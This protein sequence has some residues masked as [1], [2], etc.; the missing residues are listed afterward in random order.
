M[1]S[2]AAMR[3]TIKSVCCLV[4]SLTCAYG[5]LDPGQLDPFFYGKTCPQALS[6]VNSTVVQAI[7]KE[8]RI[9]AS[10][11]RL[12]FHDCFVNG[13]D[14]SVLLDDTSTFTGEK[15]ANANN[16]SARGFGLIDKIKKNL[17]EA[18][19]GVVSCA[20]ILAIAARDSVVM[21]GGPTWTVMLGRRDSR[22]ASL[23]VANS[24]IP[25]PASDLANLTSKFRDQGL[26][27]REMVTLS[28]AH[29]IGKAR[30]T[31]FRSH[32]YNDSN[33]DTAY[34]KSL[35][36][37]CPRSG[38]DNKLSPL[39][40]KTP[41]KFDNCYY[42]NLVAKKGLLHSDQ[43]LFNGVS[44]DSQVTQYRNN[45]KLFERDFAAAIVKMGN[46][47]P[48][49]GSRGEIR[50][51]CRKRNSDSSIFHMERASQRQEIII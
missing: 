42:R 20:D 4:L 47:M 31:V 29:T 11:L 8:P 16:N 13:C 3:I 7:L 44:T 48:L 23:S 41:T 40:Y 28:G 32:I 19:S 50:E 43:E 45:L 9:G 18:C 35:Q 51:K 22:T 12:H 38:G 33:I 1:A 25:S 34:A 39:D 6:I 17:E 15:T 24:N 26:S 10:V 46:I 37:K 14:G 21:L 5:Q 36:D 30:C 27:Q 49:T 2:M